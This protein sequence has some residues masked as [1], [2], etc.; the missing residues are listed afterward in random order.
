MEEVDGITVLALYNLSSQ[1]RK[2]VDWVGVTYGGN[3]GEKDTFSGHLH[4]QQPHSWMQ[5]ITRI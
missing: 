5:R 1:M 4:A 3:R 2:S